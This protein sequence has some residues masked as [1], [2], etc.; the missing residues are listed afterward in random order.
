MSQQ[1]ARYRRRPAEID[2]IQYRATNI[3]AVLHFVSAGHG[4]NIVNLHA[5]ANPDHGHIEIPAANGVWRADIG[6]WIVRSAD[7]ELS[8]CRDGLFRA[9]YERAE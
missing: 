7:G 5:P 4:T 2:A 1:P 9:T 8:A 6:D 3:A